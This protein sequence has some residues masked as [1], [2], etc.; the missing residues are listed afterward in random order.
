MWR[1]RRAL[2]RRRRHAL[3]ARGDFSRSRPALLDLD[4]KLQR[5]VDFDAG[6]FV[7]AGAN[8]GYE[9]SNTYWLERARK[10]RGVL[11]EPVPELYREAVRERPGSRV[12]NCALVAEDVPGQTITLRYA[13]LMTT[14]TGFRDSAEADREWVA[15]AHRLGQE[16]PEHEFAVAARSLTSVLDE[17]GVRD[18]DLLSLDVEGFE[19][20]VLQG[21][22]FDRHAPRFILVE[23]RDMAAGRPAIEAVLGDRYEPLEALTPYDML[24]R[25]R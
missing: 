3:E 12:F 4:A 8:D 19:P 24:Y 1:A 16:E 22:D 7:E 25:R 17:A 20:Q 15:D 2:S 18:V 13:G 21:L 6:V 10:W 9:Q 11:V 23:I 5:Y 14:V